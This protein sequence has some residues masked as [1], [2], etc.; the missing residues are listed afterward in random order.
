MNLNLDQNQNE[1]IL[2]ASK[3][4]YNQ[5]EAIYALSSIGKLYFI[6]LT[7]PASSLIASLQNQYPATIIKTFDEMPNT[8]FVGLKIANEQQV[9]QGYLQVK[10]FDNDVVA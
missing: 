6:S 4:K 8:M 9:E 1:Y 5:N 7:G 2:S 10:M 3:G